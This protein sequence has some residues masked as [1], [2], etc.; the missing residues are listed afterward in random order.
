MAAKVGEIGSV[1]ST[2]AA[3]GKRVDS[4]PSQS[5]SGAGELVATSYNLTMNTKH[6]VVPFLGG[7]VDGV[8]QDIDNGDTFTLTGNVAIK[9]AAW[10]AAG[11]SDQ[12]AAVV[13]SDE[14][15]ITFSTG[16]NNL[17]GYLHVWVT[18]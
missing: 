15:T 14:K 3:L 16:S 7:T 10:Q 1:S 2:E 6:V 12:V 11:V 5:Y 18:N 4:F 13:G 8:V 17:T 9:S